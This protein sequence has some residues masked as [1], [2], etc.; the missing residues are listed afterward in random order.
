MIRCESGP[1][2]FS[3]SGKHTSEMFNQLRNRVSEIEKEEREARVCE[4]EKRLHPQPEANKATFDCNTGESAYINCDKNGLF[5]NPCSS[6]GGSL[7]ER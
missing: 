2:F 3:F 4:S 6:T 1:G 7:Y 5:R